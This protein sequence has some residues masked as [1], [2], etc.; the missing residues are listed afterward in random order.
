MQA[1]PALGG[2]PARVP[3]SPAAR[4]DAAQRAEELLAR[5]ES[6][7][8]AGAEPGQRG[9]FADRGLKIRGQSPRE[10]ED[11]LARNP[12]DFRKLPIDLERPGRDPGG[13]DRPNRVTPGPNDR[14]IAGGNR[15][16]T[17]AGNG[18]RL[19]ENT[20]LRRVGR[21][22]GREFRQRLPAVVPP[23]A[24]VNPAA[25]ARHAQGHHH[26]HGPWRNGYR[27]PGWGGTSLFL[28]FNSP[29]YLW[30]G[31]TWGGSLG[32]GG[33]YRG[34]GGDWGGDWGWGYRWRYAYS[35]WGSYVR[36]GRF[37]WNT[38]GWGGYGWNNWDGYASSWYT[39]PPRLFWRRYRPLTVAPVYCSLGYGNL[40]FG[41]AWSS[42]P[43]LM[44]WG[45]DN[46][47]SP[48][49]QVLYSP[50]YVY[51]YN[52]DCN[53]SVYTTD[54]NYAAIAPQGTTT[55]VEPQ[56][57]ELEAPLQGDPGVN[58]FPQGQAAPAL[59]PRQP[60]G[61]AGEPAPVAPPAPLNPAPQNGAGAPA[62]PAPPEPGI[63]ADAP[64][65]EFGGLRPSAP[66]LPTDDVTEA[67]AITPIVPGGRPAAGPPQQRVGPA[68]E[69]RPATDLP[70]SDAAEM[71][72]DETGPK[73]T[74]PDATGAVLAEPDPAQPALSQPDDDEDRESARVF[75][76][77]G[78]QDFKGGNYKGAV[79][80]WKHALV[81]DPENGVLV[82]MF[83]QALLATGEYAQSA[84]A[85][86]QGVQLLP[87]DQWGVVIENFRE[88]Y[89]KAGDYSEQI[90]SLEKAMKEKPEDPA[91]R[92]LAGY[93][94]L[95]LG[96]PKQAID[97]FDR[98]L[99][100]A[101]RDQIAKKLREAATAK[102]KEAE[103]KAST[104][105]PPKPGEA[106]P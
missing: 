54:W 25:V 7:K 98:V 14:P 65:D 105:A 22:V 61:P 19:P 4:A 100:A 9:G 13:R 5:R 85:V 101:P 41:L 49:P 86:Q 39:P 77:K 71:P 11:Q 28:G 37:G 43:W 72:A 55:F 2:Q 97:Q 93:H 40:G 83:S 26:N 62:P 51:D 56:I 106:T 47:S 6:R 82:L 42:L 84:G 103:A 10:G 88:L 12:G 69:G 1:G 78:E 17:V 74:A 104:D 27:G 92:F 18:A 35:P 63:P 89:G 20:L 73:L 15:P 79:Y 46:W 30:P 8:V 16:G 24:P 75:A 53:Y 76:D 31:S 59:G 50:G 29:N 80:S 96:Y 34:W 33:G 21:D 3:N 87:S 32:W 45:I 91:L 90:K 81:D 60:I 58:G 36:P 57:I 95:Y 52:P 70:A 68:V 48:A 38:I 67:T 23:A 66:E 102:L 99:K 94:Y 64:R 44:N